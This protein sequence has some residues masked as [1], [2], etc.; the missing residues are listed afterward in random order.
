MNCLGL[1]LPPIRSLS[2]QSSSSTT[3][4]SVSNA[5]TSNQAKLTAETKTQERQQQRIKSSDYHSWD[6]FDV[7]GEL[8]KLDMEGLENDANKKQ[9]HSNLNDTVD[10]G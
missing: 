3:I 6:K 4:P 1:Q 2:T 7:E 5:S 9:E 10:P 8:K